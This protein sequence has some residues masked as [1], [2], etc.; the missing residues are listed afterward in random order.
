MK[1]IIFDLDN[2]LIDWQDEFLFALRN[3]LQELKIT[4]NEDKVKELSHYIDI[5][6]KFYEKLT[7]ED[8]LEFLHKKT[9]L[10]LNIEFVNKLI[11]EQKKLYYEDNELLETLEYLSQKYDL[12][13]ITNWFTET[14]KGRLKNMGALKYFKKVYGADINYYKPNKKA[15]DVILEK[16]K[17]E[18]CLSIGDSL[19][20]DVLIPLSLG[21]KA[22]WKTKNKSLEYETIE[23]IKD[24]MNIL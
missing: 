1:A 18:E 24:L 12:Y 3:V 5:F 4:I 8:F 21:M 2:T 17:N 13:V 19:E 23:N 9:G 15:F 11:E 10:S 6:E 20:N 16:Y 22:I 7:K 14:Q